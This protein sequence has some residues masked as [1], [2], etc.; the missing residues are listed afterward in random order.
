MPKP[1]AGTVYQLKVTLKDTKPPIWRRLQV[2]GSITFYKL[3]QILQIAMGW[4]N[5]HLYEFEIGEDRVGEPDPE[6]GA[7]VR[8]ARRV[9]LSQIGPGAKFSYTYDFGDD[10]EHAILVEK[11]LPPE[12]GVSYP[13]CL[14][15]RRRCPPEDC[16]GVWG[17]A[18]L[19]EA[20]QNPE[21]PE[22]AELME[23]AGG[24]FDPA[25]FDTTGINAELKSLR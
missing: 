22:H 11:V 15:G 14:T 12:E 19:L 3:H 17:Y 7:E 23:W 18:H 2:P 10:W 1:T 20:L 8:S 9:R 13:R 16:G 6:Y 25:E 5:S 21:D 4:T 24:P